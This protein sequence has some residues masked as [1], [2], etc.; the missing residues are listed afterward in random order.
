MLLELME[1]PHQKVGFCDVVSNS[2]LVP[3]NSY[4]P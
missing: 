1:V 4:V 2:T 3:H